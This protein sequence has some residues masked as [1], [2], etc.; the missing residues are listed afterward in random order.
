MLGGF[1][2]EALQLF[3]LAASEQA[4][5]FSEGEETYDFTRCMRPDGTFYGTGGTCKKGSN[6]GAKE[7]RA[8]KGKKEV[9]ATPGN[10]ANAPAAKKPRAT[11]KELGEQQRALSDTAKSKRAEARAAE[12]EYKAIEKETKGDMSKEAKK[13]R[14][15]A[16][17]KWDKA[18]TAADRAQRG[19][20]K[21][22][23]KWSKA[24]E[25]EKRA[26]MSPAQRTEARRVD[27]II[28]ERG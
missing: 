3:Q 9:T 24:G 23:E 21:A 19:W 15:E 26:K 27:K 16:G 8:K 11:V 12:K 2:E 4:Y 28:K 25:R 20:M 1:S 6:A 14:L 7:P 22:H 10:A 18:N 13:R 5:E 17:R